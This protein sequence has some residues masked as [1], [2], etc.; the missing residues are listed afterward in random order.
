MTRDSGTA[1]SPAPAD[2]AEDCADILSAGWG[3]SGQLISLG[4]L[5]DRVFRLDIDG[6]PSAV[7]KLSTADRTDRDVLKNFR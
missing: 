3:I 1:P 5:H 7:L 4:R 2:T 6:G